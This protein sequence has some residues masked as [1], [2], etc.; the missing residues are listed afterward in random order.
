LQKIDSKKYF[1]LLSIQQSIN[2]LYNM[3]VKQSSTSKLT[4][5]QIREQNSD[6]NHGVSLCI[7]RVFSNITYRQIFKVMCDARLGFVERVDVI[8]T[9]DHKRA[10]IHFKA[11]GWNMRDKFARETLTALQEGDH[12][13]MLYEEG[14]PWFWKVVISDSVRPTE[15]PKMKPRPN[16]TR[17]GRKKTLDLGDDP[18]TSRVREHNKGVDIKAEV[19]REL[20]GLKKETPPPE[21]NNQF[22]SL[23]N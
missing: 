14:K 4:R 18:I 7:P 5:E 23:S 13:E 19:S 11:G 16:I 17:V 21:A 12:L 1:L 10:Y 2:K 6:P 22:A 20:T 3:S 15:A 8:R 9:K